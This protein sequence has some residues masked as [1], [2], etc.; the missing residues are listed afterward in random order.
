[1]SETDETT[2]DGPLDAEAAREQ[3]IR[4]YHIGEGEPE[5]MAPKPEAVAPPPVPQ[6]PVP[7]TANIRIKQDFPVHFFVIPG[8]D[9]TLSQTEW[10]NV[11]QNLVAEIWQIAAE[12]QVLLE[13]DEGS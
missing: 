2:P 7:G 12:N 4:E 3:V 6:G 5:A 1:M 11:P 10:T 9:L 13:I 8:L